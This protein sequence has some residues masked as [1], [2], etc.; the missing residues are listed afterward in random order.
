MPTVFF[1]HGNRYTADDALETGEIIYQG[2][3]A[4]AAIHRP[5]RFVIWSWPSDKL[6]RGQVK[7]LR[8]K[9]TRAE[10]QGIHLAKFVAAMDPDVPVGLL[11][12]SY[13]SRLIS[14]S[15]HV[16]GGG[17]IGGERL[18]T[19]LQRNAPLRV[20]L[21]AAAMGNHWMLPGQ[22]HGQAMNSLD[23]VLLISNSRDG[24]LRWYPRLFPGPGADALGY[25]GIVFPAKLGPHLHKVEQIDAA[26]LIGKGH[27]L[28]DYYHCPAI[29][30]R[31]SSYISFESTFVDVGVRAAH[32]SHA[33][34]N[35]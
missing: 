33:K 11:G 23:G 27:N 21:M 13:G 1:V 31:A 25:T 19:S 12:H 34:A 14:S 30:Q 32:T 22:R 20:V 35:Q 16:L 7:D 10:W 5:V 2:I 29:W 3:V 18:E 4:A 17:E 15:L 24:V 6:A 26:P 28:V 9:A 8:L